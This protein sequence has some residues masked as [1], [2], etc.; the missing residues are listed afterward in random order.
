MRFREYRASAAEP[1]VVIDGSPN[2]GTVLTLTHWPGIAQPPGFEADLSA[3]MALRYVRTGGPVDARVVT[4]NHFDQDGLVGV[5]AFV[6]P[7]AALAHE[8]LLADVAAAGDFGTY[9]SRAAARASMTIWA[10][11]EPGRSPIGGQLVGSEDEQ[12]AL[13]Y[14]ATLPLLLS[15][16]LEPE[17]FSDLWAEEDERLTA[18]EAALASG[19]ITI[20]ERP[21]VDLAVVR[22]APDEPHRPGHRFT[23][24]AQRGQ[25]HPM[26][27][28]NATQ[29]VRLI[30]ISGRSYTYT[31]R[32]ETWVQYRR[33]RPLPRVDLRPLADILT[34]LDSGDPWTAD[35]PGSLTPTL[36][37]PSESRLDEASVLAELERHLREAPPAWMPYL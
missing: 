33:R 18:T 1:N 20:E 8:A 6:D 4:N 36:R 23:S 2:A 28:N 11:S 26:A 34:A 32:Y 15:M 9:R 35:P 16:V 29:C 5:F 12:C 30:E 19:T 37:S 14:E 7:D 21:A 24:N 13:L 27:L 3:E 10:Y 31:D 25:A 22:I 17:H